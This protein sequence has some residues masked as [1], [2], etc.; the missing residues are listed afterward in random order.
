MTPTCKSG[1]MIMLP[2]LIPHRQFVG[3]DEETVLL[4]AL[5]SRAQNRWKMDGVNFLQPRRNI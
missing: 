1:L 2:I 5:M 3:P 4:M